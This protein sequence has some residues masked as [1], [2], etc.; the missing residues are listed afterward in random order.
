MTEKDVSIFVEENEVSYIYQTVL[1]NVRF[2]VPKHVQ[3]NPEFNGGQV[4][5]SV[6]AKYISAVL[7]RE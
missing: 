5:N 4:P 3:Y 1:G 6:V 2:S 7:E